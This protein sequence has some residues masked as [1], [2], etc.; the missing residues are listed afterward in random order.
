MGLGLE[1]IG[2]TFAGHEEQLWLM[3]FVNY[4][5]IAG[6]T[7]ANRPAPFLVDLNLL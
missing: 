5:H 4:M 1:A 3:V 6:H 2:M 7:N